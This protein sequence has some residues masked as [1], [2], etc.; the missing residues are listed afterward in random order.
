MKK[1]VVLIALPFLLVLSSC[2]A[3]PSID[4]K[5]FLEDTLAH[6]EVFGG[7]D[8]A[9]D[10]RVR[11]EATE[12]SALSTPLIGYQINYD[13][14]NDKI[15][16]RFAAAI[17]DTDV[18]ANWKRGVAASDGSIVKAFS[19]DAKPA[20]KYY[21]SLAN[22]SGA[23]VAG[24][25][26]YAD[27]VG[28]VVFTLY[29]I[30]YTANAESYV[31]AYLTLTRDEESV[32]TSA[33]AVK[34]Q[35][36]GSESANAFTFDPT[37]TGHFLEGTING[38]VFDG[39]TNGL[40]RE[41]GNT[42]SGNYAWY[43]TVD[44]AAGDSFGSFYYS[45][46]VFQYFGFGTFFTHSTNWL[47]ESSL[48]G[49]CSPIKAGNYKLYV[50]AG[51]G[52]ENHVY[53]NMNSLTETTTLYF[54]PNSN[55]TQASARFAIYMWDGETTSWADLVSDSK[56]G[57]YKLESYNPQSYPNFKFVRMNPATTVNNWDN[58]WNESG[59]LNYSSFVGVYTC[60]VDNSSNWDNQTFTPTLYSS[61]S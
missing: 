35:V 28:F 1:K 34:V 39:G 58:K 49:Y 3:K 42:P 37:A 32:H 38:T 22:A 5:A 26:D 53:T 25:G 55:W 20:N 52:T 47:K 30:P 11:K 57:V 61:I 8:S 16:I 40:Y 24:Q 36:S 33:L 29:N 54:K 9:A 43:E 48:S 12:K 27:Y 18:E 41:S 45:P 51:S 50:S 15:A 44:L 7:F 14:A 59:N 4:D 56:T 21:T 19:D 10:L 13:S 23:I 31:A 60:Y 46:T 6:E 2:G 17:K